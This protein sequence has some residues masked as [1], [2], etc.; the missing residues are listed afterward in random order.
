MKKK[1]LLALSAL[2]LS[3]G[4]TVSSCA[5][6]QGEKGDTGDKGDTGET[7]PQGPEGK[8]GQDGKT[9]IDVIVLPVEGGTIT[10]DKFAVTEG[11]NETVTFTFTPEETTNN[12]VL[13]FTVNSTVV[14]D[15]ITPN[16]DGTLTFTLT[17][18]DSYQSVQVK[19]ATFSNAVTYAQGLVT[20]ALKA[21]SDV[22]H[23]VGQTTENGVNVKYATAPLFNTSLYAMVADANTAIEKAS[24]DAKEEGTKAQYDAAVAAANSEIAKINE[25]YSD[26]LI[27]AKENAKEEISKL[28]DDSKYSN[29]K[30]N[31]G[32]KDEDRTND[33]TNATSAIESATTLEAISNVVLTSAIK[34]GDTTL[35]NVGSYP[36]LLTDKQSALKTLDDALAAVEGKEPWM[37]EEAT[38]H[39]LTITTLEGYGVDVGTLPS[40]IHNDY[41]A[42]V[43]SATSLVKDGN[44]IVLAKEGKE[45]IEGTV[46][47]IK[48]QLVAGIE[49]SYIEEID[50]SKAIADA[51][52]AKNTLKGVIEGVISNFTYDD[53]NNTKTISDYISTTSGGLIYKIEE[54][55]NTAV[56]SQGLTAFKTERAQ[57]AVDNAIAQLEAQI[58]E[59]NA[60]DALYAS[61]FGDAVY[62][63][64]TV[65]GYKTV[66]NVLSWDDSD[67]AKVGNPFVDSVTEG[68][69]TAYKTGTVKNH[70]LWTPSLVQALEGTYKDL[71]DNLI[72]NPTSIN[73]NTF[74]K[75][76]EELNKALTNQ[77]LRYE[78]AVAFLNDELVSNFV[79]GQLNGTTYVTEEGLSKVWTDAK[80]TT[81]SALSSLAKNVN[82]SIQS[83]KDLD[84]ALVTYVDGK[85]T[86]DP[87]WKV[88][89]DGKTGSAT[90][91]AVEEF[92]GN[93]LTNGTTE[94]AIN[95]FISSLDEL[96]ASDVAAYLEQ[97]KD[98]AE[99]VYQNTISN[100]LGMDKYL[101]VKAAY[102]AKLAI[103]DGENAPKTVTAINS[104]VESVEVALG[105]VINDVDV[106]VAAGST[107][108]KYQEVT[109]W[110]GSIKQTITN[111][112]LDSVLGV[113]VDKNIVASFE[114]SG[115]AAKMTNEFATEFGFPYDETHH[116]VSFVVELPE[117]C[118]Y[119]FY[120]PS[121][122]DDEGRWKT[123]TTE[124]HGNML[125]VID[126]EYYFN[127][128]TGWD[129]VEDVVFFLDVETTDA[130]GETK[131]VTYTFTLADVDLSL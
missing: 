72:A 111:T 86:N 76:E 122:K 95:S 9:Y 70:A 83:L 30:A 104:W 10:Q 105:N 18:D 16:E 110:D 7:G 108:E 67:P 28:L 32:Y 75:V 109:K 81:M 91:D 27:L 131:T 119:K 49:A 69:T 42:Q 54:E 55:L 35:L 59:I 118:R 130:S 106:T 98:Y 56:T 93:A 34:D 26:A 120:N 101:K 44:D 100:N 5:G 74:T 117:V 17:V 80:A 85:A 97:S 96:Y 112:S 84:T 102:E 29:L 107:D 128:S 4:L 68:V 82:D 94:S 115:K 41:V 24:E 19:N 47:N 6:A 33:L 66:E 57:K 88:L 38:N 113:G 40:A 123:N 20:D 52:N 90:W 77:K 11:E 71:F 36:Q 21:I 129:S 25:A 78:G 114:V 89:F 65:V 103:L 63:G 31:E 92:V 50:S 23:L 48:D 53:R 43:S 87:D 39:D 45:A 8:P 79:T 127:D 64:E 58:D 12:L 46:K 126:V 121:N 125:A 116:Y 2:V 62:D 37:D 61:I 124:D 13:N 51:T 22:D 3:L 1:N 15:V 14:A 60:S 99:Q 73:A